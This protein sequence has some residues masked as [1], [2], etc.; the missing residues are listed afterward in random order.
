[1]TEFGKI[2]ILAVCFLAFVIAGYNVAIRQRDAIKTELLIKNKF[3]YTGNWW[4]KDGYSISV[5]KVDR[6]SVMELM[7]YLKR[8]E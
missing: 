3:Q 1:M 7:R 4:V 6:W 8:C 5:D 2:L